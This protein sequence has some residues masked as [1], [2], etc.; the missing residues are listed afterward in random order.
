MHHIWQQECTTNDPLGT[1][2]YGILNYFAS[3][4]KLAFY[5]RVFEQ[6]YDLFRD[7]PPLQRGIFYQADYF[8]LL[9]RGVMR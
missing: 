8:E 6:I 3:V 7:S 2:P 9:R 1:S 4:P 5:E